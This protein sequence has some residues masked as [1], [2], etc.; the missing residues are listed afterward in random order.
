MPEAA[1]TDTGSL[2]FALRTR[3]PVGG[4]PTRKGLALRVEDLPKLHEAVEAL[5]AAERPA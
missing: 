2:I 4:R 5:I 3:T 1:L